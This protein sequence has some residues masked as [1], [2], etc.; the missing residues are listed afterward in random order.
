[1]EIKGYQHSEFSLLSGADFELT[2][3]TYAAAYF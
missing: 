3:G 2:H 1:M